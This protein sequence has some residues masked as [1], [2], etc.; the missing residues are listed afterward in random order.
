M[1]ISDRTLAILKNFSRINDSL[2]VDPGSVLTT[3]TYPNMTIFA[4]ATVS[5][6][7][8]TP[9]AIYDLNQFL[10]LVRL[11]E[12]EQP[13]FAF[14]EKQIK[15]KSDSRRIAY[16]LA[17]PSM[18][19]EKPSRIKAI[20]PIYS[21]SIGK[22]EIGKL[23]EASSVLQSDDI[24]FRNKDGEVQA[25]AKNVGSSTSHEF[26]IPLGKSDAQVNVRVKKDV[27]HLIDKDQ[28]YTVDFAAKPFIKL[29]AQDVTYWMAGGV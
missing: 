1:Q 11:F 18:L 3:T 8:K 28:D 12:K 19:P 17:D 15:I 10:G 27:F 29:E 24:L 25:V 23:M 9:F 13:D 6:E 4:R 5:E 2:V 7:F 21:I 20:E 14:S 16:T 22:K 26:I